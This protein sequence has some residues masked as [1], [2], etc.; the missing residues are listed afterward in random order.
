MPPFD[1]R[2]RRVIR[3]R[4]TSEPIELEKEN[5]TPTAV[6]GRVPPGKIC[7][8]ISLGPAASCLQKPSLGES[9][10][11]EKQLPFP[12]GAE[13]TSLAA[14]PGVLRRF[15][16]FLVPHSAT[17]QAAALR[18]AHRTR[19]AKRRHRHAD[20]RT[21]GHAHAMEEAP[22]RKKT[23]LA[24]VNKAHEGRLLLGQGEGYIRARDWHGRPRRESGATSAAASTVTRRSRVEG[25]SCAWAEKP[26][27]VE[28][29]SPPRDVYLRAGR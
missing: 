26:V 9:K 14:A 20:T 17:Q 21:R 27:A 15:P 13:G 7:A 10:L 24:A 3:Q 28:I 11:R 8:A 2:R 16:S 23:R 18:L 12:S 22:A 19:H 5:A 1:A 4:Q 29:L 25:L 6:A